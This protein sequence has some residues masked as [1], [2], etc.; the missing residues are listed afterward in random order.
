MADLPES[1]P[2]VRSGPWVCNLSSLE[3][4][5]R[6]RKAL[7]MEKRNLNKEPKQQGSLT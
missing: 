2:A 6:T 5:E 3:R 4:Q 1:P 7:G